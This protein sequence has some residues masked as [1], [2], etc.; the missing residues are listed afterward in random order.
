MGQF[1]HLRHRARYTREHVAR[2]FSDVARGKWH[3]KFLFYAFYA[4]GPQLNTFMSVGILLKYLFFVVSCSYLIEIRQCQIYLCP[5]FYPCL[6][7]TSWLCTRLQ[8]RNFR[9]SSR[10]L[11]ELVVEPRSTRDIE[12]LFNIVKVPVV[13]NTADTP[14]SPGLLPF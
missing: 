1:Y 14:K 6:E 5:A 12:I 4:F 9:S 7:I 2:I 13:G 11:L 8:A 10:S 3:P